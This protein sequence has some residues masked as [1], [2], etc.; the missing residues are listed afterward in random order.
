MKIG[1][2]FNCE[3][4]CYQYDVL[5]S[6]HEVLQVRGLYEEFYGYKVKKSQ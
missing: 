5:G 6:Q 4:K 2:N 1:K 3:Y